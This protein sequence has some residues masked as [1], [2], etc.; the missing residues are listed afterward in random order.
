MKKSYTISDLYDPK[1]NKPY[2]LAFVFWDI[3]YITDKQIGI[4]SFSN[5]QNMRFVLKV[6]RKSKKYRLGKFVIDNIAMAC[7][8]ISTLKT[9]RNTKEIKNECE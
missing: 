9:Q 1:Q 2:S 7:Y 4:F 3:Q 5:K 8:Y 6:I